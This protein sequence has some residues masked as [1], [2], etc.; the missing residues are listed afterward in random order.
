LQ[1]VGMTPKYVHVIQTLV[2][3]GIRFDGLSVMSGPM[4]L[5]HARQR[6]SMVALFI[7]TQ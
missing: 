4:L 1:S 5:L 6:A 3:E 7:A 2:S